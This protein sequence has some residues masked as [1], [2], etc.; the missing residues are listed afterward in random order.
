MLTIRTKNIIYNQ[1]VKTFI[2]K[3]CSSFFVGGG[4][5]TYTDTIIYIFREEWLYCPTDHCESL[6]LAKFPVS[7]NLA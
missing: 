1:P 2:T 4:Q 3:Y 5:S 7:P 6:I